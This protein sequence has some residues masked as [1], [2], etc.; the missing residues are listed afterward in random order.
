MRSEVHPAADKSASPVAFSEGLGSKYSR[1][2]RI[3]R[4][5]APFVGHPPISA[6]PRHKCRPGLGLALA[7]EVAGKRRQDPGGPSALTRGLSIVAI[8][9]PHDRLRVHA[10]HRPRVGDVPDDEEASDYVPI[11]PFEDAEGA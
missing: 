7:E 5:G 9:R 11:G 3:H 8:Y 2:L 1:S 10:A 4:T 6:A